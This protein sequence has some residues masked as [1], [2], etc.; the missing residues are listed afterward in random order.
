MQALRHWTC[1]GVATLVTLAP[2]SAVWAQAQATPSKVPAV[3]VAYQPQAGT[4]AGPADEALQH[5]RELAAI[6]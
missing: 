2:L 3:R 1:C 5:E 4:P 6:R